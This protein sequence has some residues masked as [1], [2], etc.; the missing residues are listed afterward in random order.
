MEQLKNLVGKSEKHE[1]VSEALRKGT[2]PGRDPQGAIAPE[3]QK[4][5]VEQQLPGLEAEMKVRPQYDGP[6]YKGSGKLAGKAALI[7]GGDSGIGRSVAIFYAREGADVAIV[8]LPEE[9]RDAEETKA[10]VEK[11]GRR[12]LLLPGD[13][14]SVQFCKD[15]VHRTVDTFGRLDILVNNAARQVTQ[16]DLSN[17][18][19]EQIRDTYAVNIFPHF[20]VTREALQFL[21]KQTGTI[22]NTTSVTT[23]RGKDELIDY[24]T[25]KG[26]ILAFTRSLA[27][28]LSEDGIRVNAVAP[29]P[30]W[31]PLITASFKKE[32]FDKFG[33]EVPLGRAGQPEELAAAYVYLAARDSSYMTG[34]VL[35]INGGDPY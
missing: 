19:D 20:T 9:Q 26:A 6:W 32:Q 4:I 29:G 5:D 35:H 8:Y 13:L 21:P 33:K 34:Q 24:S 31:T 7:T 16:P 28:N 17:L 11:E 27:K 12:C 23:F 10:M 30:I 15:I 18:S 2:Q 25:T 1:S 3:K 14:R 22:I